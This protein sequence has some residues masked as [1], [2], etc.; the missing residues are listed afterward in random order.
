MNI[1]ELLRSVLRGRTSMSFKSAE[2][3]GS[4]WGPGAMSAPD[5]ADLADIYAI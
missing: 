3:T 1:G 4:L 5:V 2:P